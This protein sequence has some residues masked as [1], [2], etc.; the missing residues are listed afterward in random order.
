VHHRVGDP[1]ILRLIR[2]WLKAGV[3]EGGVI[4]PSDA[5]VPQGGSSSVVLSNLYLHDV[6]DLWVERIV[7]PRLHGE[8]YL[9]RYMD[10]TPVQA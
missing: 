5:G 6:L 1:R 9:I 10:G 3:L 8:A 2:R 4:E 7:K